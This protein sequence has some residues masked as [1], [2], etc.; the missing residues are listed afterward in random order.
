VANDRDHAIVVGIN[1]YA[2][3]RKLG[4][5]I[6][7]ARCFQRWLLDPLGGDVPASNIELIL[8]DPAAPGTT[9]T[10]QRVE[11]AMLKHIRAYRQTQTRQR[12]LYVFMSGHGILAGYGDTEGCRIM[13]ADASLDA[14]TRNIG[15]QSAG[16]L[17][18][19]TPIFEEIV[20]FGDSCRELTDDVFAKHSVLTIER[21]VADLVKEAQ[22]L[23][24][25]MLWGFACKN[26][27]VVHEGLLPACDGKG[28]RYRRGRFTYALVCGLR[29]A[30]GSDGAVTLETLEPYVIELVSRIAD[31]Q[32]PELM[33]SKKIVLA[34][35][36]APPPARVFV[37][38]SDPMLAFELRDGDR[39]VHREPLPS[40]PRPSV[41]LALPEGRYVL[42]V[43]GRPEIAIPVI[44]DEVHV[45]L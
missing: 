4:G 19:A 15:I 40:A 30:V 26:W 24:V 27:R 17:L 11:G 29:R 45:E 18:R 38:L 32:V 12:R 13:M 7:D 39:V 35:P 2:E 34:R 16:N 36:G 41:E 5:A 33:G 14:I 31:N 9:P 23:E 6:N 10:Q 21:A 3:L 43:P 25:P 28:A 8:S 22:H 37:D 1:D 20:L 44:G 42:A